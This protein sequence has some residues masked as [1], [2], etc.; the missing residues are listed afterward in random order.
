MAE[1]AVVEEEKDKTGASGQE[2]DNVPELTLEKAEK[3]IVGLEKKI[4][5][6]IRQRMKHKGKRVD[7]SLGF[8]ASSTYLGNMICLALE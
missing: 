8:F 5:E 4:N 7:I 1:G 3:L 2:E 6:N